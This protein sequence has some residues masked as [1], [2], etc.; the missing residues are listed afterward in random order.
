MQH[1]G[2]EYQGE[3]GNLIERLPTNFADVMNAF[4]FD[5]PN[6]WEAFKEKYPWT[7]S[8]DPYGDTVFNL[9]QWPYLVSEFTG[10][11]EETEDD[12][13]KSILEGLIL[14]LRKIENANHTYLKFIG[15]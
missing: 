5:G 1:I 13:V 10:L 12:N 8:I 9:L 3:T 4:P 15:D 7:A 6:A 11:R 14:F 2:I